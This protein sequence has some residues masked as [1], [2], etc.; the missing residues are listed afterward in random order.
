VPS[1]ECLTS[2]TVISPTVLPVTF[3]PNAIRFVPGTRVKWKDWLSCVEE[4]NRSIN[5]ECLKQAIE[6]YALNIAFKQL[7]KLKFRRCITDIQTIQIFWFL[8][9]YKTQE[10]TQ[11]I[12]LD[13][14]VIIF[15]STKT[16]TTRNVELLG[17]FYPK[18][19][20]RLLGIKFTRAWYIY[21][22]FGH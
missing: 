4:D 1:G 14:R 10:Q 6:L 20:T 12:T 19:I 18:I 16:F 3:G 5:T 15:N 22:S 11:F 9:D 2:W 17:I 7:L 8:R 13:S 21:I